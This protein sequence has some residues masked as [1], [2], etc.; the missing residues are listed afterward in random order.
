MCEHGRN[1]LDTSNLI[2]LGQLFESS[3]HSIPL[4]CLQNVSELE[5][6]HCKSHLSSHPISPSSISRWYVNLINYLKTF[7]LIISSPSS[8][9]SQYVNLVIYL[10]SNLTIPF[11]P[12]HLSPG[13]KWACS[14]VYTLHL[15][16]LF[17]RL[18]IVRQLGQL[19]NTPHLIILSHP[20][21]VS[22][23]YVNIV[24]YLNTPSTNHPTLSSPSLDCTS[25]W[26]IIW[27]ALIW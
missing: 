3:D 23:S 19:L 20:S 8:V 13:S 24:N 21:S 7:N 16:I 15:I 6:G 17:L 4:I 2:I 22:R 25:T 11:P 18:Q 9:S 5:L 12:L 26:S 1:C 10:T 14:I 27:I